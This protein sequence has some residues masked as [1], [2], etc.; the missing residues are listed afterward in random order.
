M[1]RTCPAWVQAAHTFPERF[2]TPAQGRCQAWF[3]KRL[4]TKTSRETA[5]G[6]RRV[7][8]RVGDWQRAGPSV[9]ALRLARPCVNE[10]LT[11]WAKS[12][13]LMW[14]PASPCYRFR[15]RFTAATGSMSQAE[16]PKELEADAARPRYVLTEPGVGYRL[17]AE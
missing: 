8:V 15:R 7:W 16:P 12:R 9:L 3:I 5:R 10:L 14:S 4:T 11:P 13:C 2:W 17:A 1:V 6:G